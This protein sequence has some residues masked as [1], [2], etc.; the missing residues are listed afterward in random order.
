MDAETQDLLQEVSREIA[1]GLARLVPDEGPGL[2]VQRT[3]P[4]VMIRP[5]TEEAAVRR[6]GRRSGQQPEGFYAT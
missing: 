2:L 1:A 4:V 3:G 5:A 6:V